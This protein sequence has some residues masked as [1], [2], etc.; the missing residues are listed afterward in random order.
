MSGSA[1]ANGPRD[2]RIVR[3]IRALYEAGGD[4]EKFGAALA[5]VRDDPRLSEPMRVAIY[6]TLAQEA[7][8]GYVVAV[9]G[10]PID[11][12]AVYGQSFPADL[13]QKL[14]DG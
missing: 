10:Q 8:Q 12:E 4:V 3:H 5:E 6:K 11:Y 1:D 13:I 2:P 7:M 14:K 9:S